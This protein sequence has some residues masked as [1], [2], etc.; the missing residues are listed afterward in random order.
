MSTGERWGDERSYHTNKP[1]GFIATDA[2]IELRVLLIRHDT[3]RIAE[4]PQG[5][6]LANCDMLILY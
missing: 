2:D 3:L 1:A 4:F 5:L 6:C